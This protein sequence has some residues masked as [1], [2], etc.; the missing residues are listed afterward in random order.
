MHHSDFNESWQL[1]GSFKSIFPLKD[2]STHK[3]C[4]YHYNPPSGDVYIG[5]FVIAV[6]LFKYCKE[7]V[8]SWHSAAILIGVDLHDELF[9][10]HGLLWLP[11][12]SFLHKLILFI[13]FK[14]YFFISFP[15]NI[16]TIWFCLHLILLIKNI[17]MTKYKCIQ[18]CC[19]LPIYTNIYISLI[20]LS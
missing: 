4:S 16:W 11:R 7:V 19:N 2:S 15:E 13:F 10:D 5:W 20:L 12:F 18:I 8:L 1:I 14:L 9:Y 3:F 17:G 6:V